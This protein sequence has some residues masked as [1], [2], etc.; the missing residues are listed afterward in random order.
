MCNE[1]I[2]W[3]GTQHTL[4]LHTPDCSADSSARA[5]AASSSSADGWFVVEVLEGRE[6]DWLLGGAG[7]G[8]GRAKPGIIVGS[9]IGSR[10]TFFV[11]A[12]SGLAAF[13]VFEMKSI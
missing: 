4:N 3:W 2:Q 5:N 7:I 11:F 9:T 13:W 10:L 8:G 1:E 12:D 6:D